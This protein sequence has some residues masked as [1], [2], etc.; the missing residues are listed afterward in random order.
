M[1]VQDRYSAIQNEVVRLFHVFEVNGRV[2]T[3]PEAPTVR[4]VDQDG[5]TTLWTSLA[6]S[7]GAGIYYVDYSVPINL[8]IGRYYDE[9]NFRF[10]S[11]DSN[12]RDTTYFEVYPKDTILNFSTTVVSQK[13][14]DPMQ[15]AVRQ[16]AGG[17][18]FEVQHLPMYAEQARRTG[19]VLRRDFAYKNW[20]KD[21]RPIMRVNNRIVTDGWYVDYNGNVFFQNPLDDSDNV[22]AS[23]NFAYFNYTELAS[24]INIGISAMNSLPPVSSYTDIAQIP[25]SWYQGVLIY[26]AIQALRRVLLGLTTQEIN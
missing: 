26:A 19:E 24:F 8:P 11:T 5:T 13:L 15:S 10:T 20:N 23:Y 21:P 3:P 25:S 6:T 4:I 22:I 16:L 18:L 7:I 1:V 17:Y 12:S 14:S 9:W 2:V